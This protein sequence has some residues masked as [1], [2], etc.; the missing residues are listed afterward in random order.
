MSTPV[1]IPIEASI[2]TS[3]GCPHG[4]TGSCSHEGH[5]HSTA[6]TFEGQSFE[7]AN[8]KWGDPQQG[9]SGGVVTW[10][11]ATANRSGQFNDVNFSVPMPTFFMQEVRDAFDAWEAV[12]DIDFV[13]V[14]DSNDVNIRVGLG[15]LD[16][17]G[18]PGQTNTVGTAFFSF[19]SDNTF[20]KA[21]VVMDVADYTTDADS[22]EFFLTTLHEIGHAIGFNHEDDVP[23]IMST[24]INTSITGLTADDIEGA[25][26]LYGAAE[27]APTDDF[28]PDGIGTNGALL[29]GGNVAG[30]IEVIGDK[31]WFSITL[32]AGNQYQFDV[33]GNTLAN[34]FLEL[35]DSSGT[36][37]TSNNNSGEGDN[38][39]ISFTP[40]TS[41]TYFLVASEAG[42]GTGTYT[43]S[44]LDLGVPSATVPGITVSEGASDAP[45][46]TATTD[47][48]ISGDTFSGELSNTADKDF[49]SITLTAGTQYTFDLQ[50][51]GAGAG[52]LADPFLVLRDAN[53]N[54]VAQDDDSGA[55]SDARIVITPAATGIYYL[56]ART[57]GD[58]G[59]TYAL[60]TSPEERTDSSETPTPEPDPDPG[61][62]VPG[63]TVAEGSTDAAGSI[64]TT[65]EFISGD[66]FDGSLESGSD[67]DFVRIELTAGTQYTFDLNGAGS[68]EGTL[69][70]GFLVLRNASGGF[71]AQDDDGGTGTDA[72]IVFTPSESGTFYISART[73]SG[74]GGD[75]LLTT[76]PN[77]RTEPGSNPDPDPDPTPTPG[78]TVQEGTT[79]APG[80]ISSEVAI[81]VGD[82]FQGELDAG[83]DRDFVG[84]QLSAGTSYTFDIKGADSGAGT[85]SDPFLVLRDADGNFVDQ[86]DDGGVGLDSQLVFTPSMTGTYFLSVRNFSGETGTYELTATTGNG[87]QAAQ[88]AASFDEGY[89]VSANNALAALS[90]LVDEGGIG[91]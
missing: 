81:S 8:I 16:G 34:S 58:A 14:E 27:N 28:T 83:T 77:E 85:L 61:E 87:A 3:Q 24:L 20:E 35:R 73:F 75:Y 41:G 47:V 66:T 33:V 90:R 52:T 38:S 48:L 64:E 70:D 57:F 72:Q 89:S 19:F 36:L 50:G 45:G 68:G 56:S 53:G 29:A 63:I 86:D 18:Q 15:T 11:F 65:A 88:V 32:T 9:T 80:D 51:A 13:E 6:R 49:V 84:I 55:G 37:I 62:I 25:Q 7:L 5:L 43:I 21:F 42:N 4:C 59:G 39:R 40:T 69:P 60:V 44:A 22:Q 10:S 17:A 2:S 31:D 1:R 82:T 91:I 74:E 30:E 54:F 12:A 46:T 79:D 23:S 78:Q 67:R 71:V 26:T 76:S